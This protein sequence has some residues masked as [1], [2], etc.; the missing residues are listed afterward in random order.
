MAALD[1]AVLDSAALNDS[2]L[3]RRLRGAVRG[4]DFSFSGRSFLAKVVDVI[5]GEDV[6]VAF[7]FGGEL[8][9]YRARM[10]GYHGAP[11]AVLAERVAG[12]IVT[13]HCAEFDGSGRIPVMI[14]DAAGENVN[15]WM[16]KSGNGV[17]STPRPAGGALLSRTV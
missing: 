16:I 4:A 2:S 13:I 12:K 8:V 10:A 17:P 6:R 3:R 11:A 9:Q 15:E 14:V 1:R 7:E 5:D